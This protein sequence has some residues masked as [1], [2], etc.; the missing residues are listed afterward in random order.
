M[1]Y[2]HSIGLINPDRIYNLKNLIT[3]IFFS[4]KNTVLDVFTKQ[5]KN[6]EGKNIQK[7]ILLTL[8]IYR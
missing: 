6:K 5:M 1:F 7:Q 2:W 3:V 4:H 8:R